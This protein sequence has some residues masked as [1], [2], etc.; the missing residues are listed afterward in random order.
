MFCSSCGYQMPD[1]TKYCTNCG[2]RL[3]PADRGTPSYPPDRQEP[4][5]DPAPAY[6]NMPEK[7]K[8]KHTFWKVL[9][10]VLGLL[11]AAAFIHIS[12]MQ[13]Y[14]YSKITVESDVY[15]KNDPGFADII[16][17]FES[18]YLLIDDSGPLLKYS[19]LS[20][21]YGRGFWDMTIP[22]LNKNTGEDGISVDIEYSPNYAY[23]TVT[24]SESGDS[25]T[26]T[27]KKASFREKLYYISMAY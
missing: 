25:V 6:P 11:V 24:E 10:I 14:R 18:G 22:E 4:P 12:N 27:F 16:D 20:T 21:E 17:L 1:N 19:F 9:L 15:S 26:L 3:I 2:A 23:F 5:Y 8:K 7:K 13:L